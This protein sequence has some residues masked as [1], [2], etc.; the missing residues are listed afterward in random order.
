MDN[1]TNRLRR[2]LIAG[3]AGALAA[4]GLGALS[5]PP[6]RSQRPSTCRSSTA[7]AT[8]WPS[9]RSGR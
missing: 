7:G 4:A 3:G 2:R 9:R 8:W 5:R 1:D 6:S